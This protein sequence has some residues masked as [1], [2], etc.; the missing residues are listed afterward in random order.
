MITDSGGYL[1]DTSVLHQLKVLLIGHEIV[2]GHKIAP[3][4][5]RKWGKS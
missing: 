2:I 4:A 5:W 1:C 3:L